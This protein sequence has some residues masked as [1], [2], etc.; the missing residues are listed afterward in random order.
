LKDD[1]ED[2]KEYER[3]QIVLVS[4]CGEGSWTWNIEVDDV[5]NYDGY[6]RPF[7]DDGDD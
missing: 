2:A 5:G 7:V 6:W 1:T 4:D 3:E